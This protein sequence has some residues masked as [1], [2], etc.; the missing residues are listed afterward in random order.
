MHCTALNESTE[1]SKKLKQAKV[2]C[3]KIHKK[4]CRQNYKFSNL[5]NDKL[6]YCSTN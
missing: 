5:S 2:S 3:K 1:K 6:T 4:N